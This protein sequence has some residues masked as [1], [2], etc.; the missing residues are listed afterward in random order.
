MSAGVQRGHPLHPWLRANSAF[1][2]LS[3]V[4]MAAFSGF[5]PAVLGIGSWWVYVGIGIALVLYGLRLWWL[6]RRP[7]DPGEA[8]LIL[9]ADVA[10]VLASLVLIASGVLS[11][12]GAWIVASVAVVI[13]V[14]AAGQWRSL[15][16]EGLHETAT[17]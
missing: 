4:L 14:F 12:T 15:K 6:G 16:R 10:W 9:F 1:S 7:V 2:T 11:S 8:R 3:G 17:S 13:G 5:L